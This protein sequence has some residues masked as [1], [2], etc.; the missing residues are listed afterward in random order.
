MCVRQRATEN[1]NRNIKHIV[2]AITHIYTKLKE[3]NTHI[4]KNYEQLLDDQV[5]VAYEHTYST[6][7]PYIHTLWQKEVHTEKR[8][9]IRM[10][11]KN[12]MSKAQTKTLCA[13]LC[14]RI[15]CDMC[16]CVYVLC[17]LTCI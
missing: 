11:K 3:R 17:M 12:N 14:Q 15:L 5:N 2:E 13:G 1:K 8:R 7:H 16:L 9:E 10:G 4:F 6:R